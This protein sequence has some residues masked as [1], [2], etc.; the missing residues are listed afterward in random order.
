MNG[1]V[2]DP[3]A[4]TGYALVKI[5]GD[6]MD[7][8][9]Y[10]IIDVDSSS[11]YVGDWCIDLMNQIRKLIIDNDIKKIAVE[12]YFFSSK[13]AS[14]GNV[15]GAYRTAIHILCRELGINYE[16]LNISLWKKF[17]SGRSTPTKEQKAKWGHE[18]A[19]KLAIQEALWLRY[20]FRFPDHSLSQKTGKPI[21]FRYDVVD[22]VA[23]S[24]FWGRIH[25]NLSAVTLSK[26]PEQDIGLSKKTKKAFKYE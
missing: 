20:G 3:G 1:L 10:G 2:L 12:D 7:I 6:T 21:L 22:A 25:L 19:K 11:E 13:F 14:G 8:Y 24:V 18:A 9:D 5:E 16:I 4:S 26:V 15:N 17:V 23:Q